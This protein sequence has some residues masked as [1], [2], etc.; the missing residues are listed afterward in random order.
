VGSKGL[1]QYSDYE[2]THSLFNASKSEMCAE[3]GPY[4]DYDRPPLLGKLQTWYGCGIDDA[5]VYTL[6]AYPEGRECVVAL[7]A[8]I[9]D[10]ADREAI[11]HLAD[12][13][14]VDCRR[15]TSGP[16][17]TPSAA[18]SSSADAEAGGTPTDA[19]PEPTAPASGPASAEVHT[20]AC[21]DPAYMAQNPGECG[22]TGY[23]PVS[24]PGDNYSQGVVVVDDTPDCARPEDVLESGLCAP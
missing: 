16:L 24:D 18:T 4:K 6:A 14:E 12:T 21:S 17:A 11:E 5:T 23:N 9:S 10:E 1:T 19:S 2:L 20:A 13:V 7:N 15:V 3:A 22:A 8:R